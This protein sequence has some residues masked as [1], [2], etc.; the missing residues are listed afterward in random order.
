M[1]FGDG[2]ETNVGSRLLRLTAA[3]TINMGQVCYIDVSGQADL[4]DA[5]SPGGF[6]HRA[7][8]IAA[9]NITAGSQGSFYRPGDIIKNIS[10][11]MDPTNPV[12]LSATAGGITQDV[13]A[14]TGGQWVIFLGYPINSTDLDFVEPE[15]RA[16]K[17]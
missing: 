9:E 14:F 8:Y 16:Q 4:A 11:G 12:F 17:R 5:D 3:A 7:R 2:I 13:S 6:E 15:V 1:A 10:T